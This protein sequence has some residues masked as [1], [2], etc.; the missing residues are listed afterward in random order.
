MGLHV[1]QF[2]RSEFTFIDKSLI[3]VDMVCQMRKLQQDLRLSQDILEA[4]ANK[5]GHPVLAI[6]DEI[7][8]MVK[9]SEVAALKE[10]DRV[11]ALTRLITDY[12]AS[13]TGVIGVPLNIQKS[14]LFKNIEALYTQVDTQALIADFA[15]ISK[16]KKDSTEFTKAQENYKTCQDAIRAFDKGL[17]KSIYNAFQNKQ[18]PAKFRS[19]VIEVSMPE[20]DYMKFLIETF[21]STWE[22]RAPLFDRPVTINGVAID[23]L[24]TEHRNIWSK[25]YNQLGLGLL[26]KRLRYFPL[27]RE[28]TAPVLEA[29]PNDT[30]ADLH[31]DN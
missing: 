7:L 23:S 19:V 8:S 21:V 2:D 26:T 30:W 12:R 17:K 3:A 27:I 28:R 4:T 18:P 24:P 5:Y 25:K 16:T 22:Q 15:S 13:S 31:G 10:A 14:R 11:A 20:Y 9:Q 29:A 6:Q 1:P